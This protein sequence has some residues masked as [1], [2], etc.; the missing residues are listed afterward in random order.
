MQ[1]RNRA[2]LRCIGFS[3][4]VTFLIVLLAIS[5]NPIQKKPRPD[6]GKLLT[7]VSGKAS[8]AFQREVKEVNPANRVTVAEGYGTFP[9]SFEVNEGQVNN[10][11]R[12]LSRGSGYTLFLTSSEAVLSLKGHS[13]QPPQRCS[14]N[15]G[16][17]EPKGAADEVIRLK[18]LG[19]NP[20][21][22]ISGLDELPGKSN[23][24]IG[25]DP[26]NWHKDVATYRKVKYEEVYPQIDLLYYGNQQQLEYDWI[27]APGADPNVIKFSVESKFRPEI[28]AGGNLV[29][30]DSGRL[31]LRKPLI[32]QESN[33]LRR[34]I[35][36]GYTIR[37]NMEVG[38]RVEGY[39]DTLPLV[40]DPILIYSSYLGGSNND[41]GV[42][43]AV[44][45]SGNAYVAG[46]TNSTNFPTASLF[47]PNYGG[48]SQDV[49]ITKFNSSG[50]A[51]V[52]STYLG[53]SS[54]DYAASI[55]VDSAGNAYVTGQT[56]STNFP[57]VSPFQP[58]YGGGNQDAFVTK[59]NSSGNALAYSTYLGGSD[60][61]DAAG[62]AVDF[63]DNAYVTG[64]TYSF[65]F[66][67]VSAFQA[68]KSASWDAFVSKFDA[69]GKT[70]SYSTYLG[71]SGDDYGTAIALDSH[72][73]AYVAGWTF[74]VN[75]PTE[76][77]FQTN[78]NG[79]SDAFVTKLNASGKM[80]VY[81]TY[82]GGSDSDDAAGIAVDASDTA[83]V[84]GRTYS[85]NFPTT[86]AFQTTFR[87]SADAFVT[88][89]N[90]TGNALV[91][92]SYL[93]GS[94]NDQGAGI[95]VDSAGNASIIG[96][97][98]SSNF[99]TA[100]PIQNNHRGG[101]DVFITKLN[102]SGNALVYSTYLGGSGADYGM[103]IA[104]E[105]T[106]NA[107]VAG[108]TNST[109]FPTASPFRPNNRG[110]SDAFV[111]K[112]RTLKSS[113]DLMI[114]GG[115]ASTT[116]T[117]GGCISIEIGYATASV[118]AGTTPYGIAVFSFRQNDVVVSEAAVPASPPT[119]SARIFVDY[120]SGVF[121]APIGSN[122]GPV[123][124]NTGLA[125]VN[126]GST[127]ANVTYTLR[128]IDGSIITTGQGIIPSGA[129]LAKLI[130]ELKEAAPDFNLPE[131]FPIAIQFGSLDIESN[132]P[133]SILAIRLT[134]NQ[135]DEII[136]T[137]TPIADL[138]DPLNSQQL[139]FPQ[140]A[141]G[142]GYITTLILLNTSDALETGSFSIFDDNGDPLEVNNVGGTRDSTFKYAIQ[143]SG[144]FMFQTDGFPQQANVG[145]L[146][147][148]PDP[149]SSSPVGAGVFSL[150]QEGI[151]VTESGV[152][153]AIPTTHARIYIDQS[154]NH[155]TGLAIAD[156]SGTG[157]NVT[158]NAF[159]TNGSV[160]AGISKGPVN[161]NGNGHSAGFVPELISGLPA[162]FSGVL[163]ISSTSSFVAL[164]IRSL[165]NSRDNFLATTF[166]IA[167]AN[168]PAPTPMVFPQIADGGGYLTEFI[169][170]STAGPASMTL[171]FYGEDGTPL[172]VVK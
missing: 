99:P 134:L 73:N 113:L 4:A 97:T 163:D 146:Q 42:G 80:L 85:T 104:L 18:L 167:D 102:T 103:G 160:P 72:N 11:V 29:L 20:N 172:Y 28:D 5:L 1:Y 143:P 57:T 39:D 12:F 87:G 40:I 126:R 153:T 88:K 25:N 2:A 111:A 62:I 6:S 106:C 69:S 3:T 55:A 137:T 94:N 10:D 152:P 36:G 33:G 101:G 21:P 98:E 48:G 24:F 8:Q 22:K 65:N 75:F 148:T 90:A 63:S 83:Y 54:Y 74:S 109:N 112:I 47:Q 107:Y 96:T 125:L 15:I 53:G 44:D 30:D 140:F 120:R 154:G 16:F 81:S 141:D 171:N 34:E 56:N 122:A 115:G 86:N 145:S 13:S 150:T 35:A 7:G 32:Y 159:Q 130:H 162:N 156:P 139:Y 71:G 31:Q 66:P 91:Y 135:R 149:D 142:G 76:S 117:D 78:L 89:L 27:V 52:Y 165:I 121:T 131:D 100:S 67:T 133:L 60:N 157:I 41:E 119:N 49:F 93:G 155:S 37:E 161:L 77:S 114:S 64:R 164:T 19:A 169:L 110:G 158:V 58:N 132:Q 118:N 23:Y 79:L 170:L 51:L 128:K 17:T 116:A 38:F 92:S 138:T 129:H 68:N 124:I 14:G 127:T 61:E 95:A 147:L 45:T 151:L 84:T 70:L 123:D 144:V 82:L 166:P 136:Y 9:L 59:L 26:A 108:T 43:I 50:N 105:S 46:Y 168:Q